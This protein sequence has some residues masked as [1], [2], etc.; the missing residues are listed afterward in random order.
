[1]I[2]YGFKVGID[3]EDVIKKVIVEITDG[4]DIVKEVTIDVDKEYRV[5]PYKEKRRKHRDRTGVVRS[6][7][8]YED[9][10]ELKVHLQFSDDNSFAWVNAQ[11]LDYV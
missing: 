1:M 3:E 7:K 11:D 6:F 9:K 4:D 10:G 5:S 2:L 8:K